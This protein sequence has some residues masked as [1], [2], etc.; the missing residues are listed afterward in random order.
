MKASKNRTFDHY[1]Y[2]LSSTD[3]VDEFLD[4]A[5]LNKDGFLNYA[6]YV[7]AMNSSQEEKEPV[8]PPLTAADLKTA[9]ENW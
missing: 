9:A 1:L 6:E 2:E 4:F 5:D 7:K 3:V 8:A